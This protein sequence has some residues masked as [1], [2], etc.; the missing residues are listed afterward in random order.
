[1]LY[2][3]RLGYDIKE[4]LISIVLITLSIPLAIFVIGAL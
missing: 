3:P 4:D 1:M 2:L